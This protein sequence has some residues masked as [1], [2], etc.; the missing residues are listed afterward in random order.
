MG[1]I[2]EFSLRDAIIVSGLEGLI[3]NLLE[4]HHL[5]RLSK[6]S[7]I[8]SCK[9]DKLLWLNIKQVSSAKKRGEIDVVFGISLK[10]NKNIREPRV[11]S[12]GTPTLYRHALF[13]FQKWID[14]TQ[15]RT[16]DTI[17]FKLSQ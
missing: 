15:R 13:S 8:V 9:P 4:L 2:D 11:I 3:V 16:S 10:Y 14:Q 1:S 5:W 17:M 12:Y 6:F 7:F